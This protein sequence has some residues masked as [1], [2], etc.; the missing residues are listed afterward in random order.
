[1]K[2][3]PANRLATLPAFVLA[4]ALAL[5]QA[6]L[7]RSS[8][9]NQPMDI[10]AGHVDHSLDDSKPATLSGG[11]TITQG[12]LDIRASTAVITQ[13][14][15]D[16]TRV[17]LTGAPVTLKQQMDDGTPMTATANRI[18][19]DLTTEIVVFTGNVDIRQPRGTLGGQRV[20]YNMRTNQVTGGEPGKSRVKMRILPRGARGNGSGT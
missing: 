15:G 4:A 16:P 20:V 18:D 3:L 1:M 12:T 14:G 9:R 19:Y 7:A 10:D 5:P 6:A 13:R 17:L 2:G 11:V 8:D